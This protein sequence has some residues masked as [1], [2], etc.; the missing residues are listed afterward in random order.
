M[1]K[2]FIALLLFA[3]ACSRQETPSNEV[4]VYISAG[5]D[6]NEEP[7]WVLPVQNVPGF[8]HIYDSTTLL[9]TNNTTNAQTTTKGSSNSFSIVLT[10]GSYNM[11]MS[12]KDPKVV[13][14]YLHFTAS[15]Q[16]ANI[17][18]GGAPIVLPADTKQ[19]LLMVAKAAVTSAPTMVIAGKTYTMHLNAGNTFY[20][21]YINAPAPVTV[22]LNMSIG[23]RD[24]VLTKNNKYLVANQSGA[25]I[26]TDELILNT[27]TI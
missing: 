18:K 5:I 13:E 24:L 6:F 26:T 8:T 14:K 27:V 10:E 23:S 1:R 19:A 22:K 25:T 9:T 11:Y 16:T 3:T 17:V 12:T 21:A 2:L 4:R 7:A 20:Y 15:T